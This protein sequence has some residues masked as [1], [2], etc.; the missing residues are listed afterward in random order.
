MIVIAKN[1]F[2][3]CFRLKSVSIPSSVTVIGEWAFHACTSISSVKLSEGLLV[4]RDGA[5][6]NCTSLTNIDLPS[7]LITI[8]SN[9][10]E[11][12]D[13]YSL[14][15]PAAVSSIQDYAV[16]WN[17][18][19]TRITVDEANLYY[20]SPAGSNAIVRSADRMLV[21]ACK[22]SVIPDDVTSLF[23][24]AFC[25]CHGMTSFQV[26]PSVE[27]IYSGAFW[28]LSSLKHIS[29]PNSLRYMDWNA[30]YGCTGLES[31]SSSVMEPFAFSGVFPSEVFSQATLYIPA[32]AKPLYETT[33]DWN[34]FQNIVELE[35]LGISSMTEDGQN[36]AVYSLSGVLL[37]RVMSVCQL[38]AGIYV[39]NGRKVV[40][41]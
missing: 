23:S 37:K 6:Y 11:R 3:G 29:L 40:V 2:S 26:P 28:G 30:F 36:L 7:S 13:L 21:L 38:P 15:I 34:K 22:T 41:K 1:A 17:E 18:N 33:D 32:G 20:E 24:G 9:A 10:L 5:F 27:T 16:C 4:L 31:I 8:G 19:L 12:T 39:V 25:N 14:Y 35:E